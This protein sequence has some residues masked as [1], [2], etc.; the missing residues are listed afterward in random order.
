MKIS[1]HNKKNANFPPEPKT[2]TPARQTTGTF[3]FS[4]PNENFPPQQKNCQFPARTKNWHTRQTDNWNFFFPVVMKI[5]R[6]NKKT[7]IFPP[8]PKTDTPARQTTGTFFFS[9][10]NENFSATTKKLPISR[11]NDG[12]V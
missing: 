10:R 11:Q 3:Y 12:Y 1:L 6:H 4:G 5:F 8:E 7:A 9:G 2:D